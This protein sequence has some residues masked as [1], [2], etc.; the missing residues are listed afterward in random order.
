MFPHEKFWEFCHS[1][2][3]FLG[4]LG[5]SLNILALMNKR[6]DSIRKSEDNFFKSL[7]EKLQSKQSVNVGSLVWKDGKENERK[8]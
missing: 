1:Y 4:K 8:H 5:F 6:M 3:M 2:H 7:K